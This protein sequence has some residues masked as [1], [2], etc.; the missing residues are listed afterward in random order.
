MKGVLKKESTPPK[1]LVY[2][3]LLKKRIVI[4]GVEGSAVEVAHK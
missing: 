1:L 2:M 4:D 3:S